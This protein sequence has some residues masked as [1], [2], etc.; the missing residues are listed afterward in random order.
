MQQHIYVFTYMSF[1]GE[2]VAESGMA[3]E[4][5]K[6]YS[7]MT[8]YAEMDE[9]Q[10]NSPPMRALRDA[11]QSP[12]WKSF[13]TS[14][15]VMHELF[16]DPAFL[17]KASE[18]YPVV[19][20]RYASAPPVSVDG[21]V[22]QVMLAD[23]LA[24]TMFSCRFSV[25]AQR[26][27][28]VFRMD[29]IRRDVSFLWGGSEFG[30]YATQVFNCMLSR[31]GNAGIE[32]RLGAE[33]RCMP[34]HGDV[35]STMMFL[36]G[37]AKEVRVGMANKVVDATRAIGVQ[38]RLTVASNSRMVYDKTRVW[39]KQEIDALSRQEL[40]LV[41]SGDPFM[42]LRFHDRALVNLVCGGGIDMCSVPEVLELDVNRLED[43]RAS[44]CV[45]E[46]NPTMRYVL[47]ELVTSQLPPRSVS[48]KPVP[49]MIE[50]AK[51]LRAVMVVCRAV[52]GEMTMRLTRSLVDDAMA[53][54]LAAGSD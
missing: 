16:L 15:H 42:L 47:C 40:E 50:S 24:A 43:I 27:V 51:K 53:V 35:A 25:D 7:Y 9:F 34:D 5:K 8:S 29:E 6:R 52:H 39:L 12:M 13:Y 41:H 10:R 4:L 46:D 3:V 28:D 20:G 23:M 22:F 49:S 32:E 37:V 36:F 54:L 48:Y 1:L 11:V 14:A 26:C 33:W 30:A 44:L 21:S 18:C 31:V 38:Y 2:P 45:I 19:T 17:F